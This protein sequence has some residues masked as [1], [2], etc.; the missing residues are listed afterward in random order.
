M[1]VSYTINLWLTDTSICHLIFFTLLCS[2]VLIPF[3]PLGATDYPADT[4]GASPYSSTIPQPSPPP[5]I[6]LLIEAARKQSPQWIQGLM[7]DFKNPA[8]WAQKEFST[9]N[10][11]GNEDINS[12]VPSRD[13]ALEKY[14]GMS[15]DLR[16]VYGSSLAHPAGYLGAEA[17]IRFGQL[18]ESLSKPWGVLSLSY[19][20][21]NTSLT[22]SD[23]ALN[24]HGTYNFDD[25]L[26]LNAGTRQNENLQSDTYIML[27]WTLN[28][29]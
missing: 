15:F 3:Y 18:T 13:L 27:R 5:H 24:V 4:Q 29:H 14:N 22:N 12:L 11:D 9:A 19:T 28:N 2:F 8:L 1:R 7:D 10:V 17:S 23:H 6:G 26:S 20:N 21:D 25:K 16:P